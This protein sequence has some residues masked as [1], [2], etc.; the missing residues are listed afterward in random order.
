MSGVELKIVHC[1]QT[2]KAFPGNV[3]RERDFDI[4]LVRADSEAAKMAG[5]VLF[6]LEPDWLMS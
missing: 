3:R 1:T 4:G 2:R 5:R 6:K